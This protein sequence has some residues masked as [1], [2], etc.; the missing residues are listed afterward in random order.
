[1]NREE[2]IEYLIDNGCK[3]IRI[4]NQGYCVMRNVVNAAISGIPVTDPP[5]SATI[6]RICK[7]LSIDPPDG[8]D[9]AK[10][11]IEEVHEKF[12]K[13]PFSPENGNL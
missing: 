5:L 8:Y 13:P 12:K 1:M 2:F 3:V 7:T 10:H 9:A 6:C 4:A 11:L